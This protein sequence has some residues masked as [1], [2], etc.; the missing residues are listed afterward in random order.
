MTTTFIRIFCI[1]YLLYFQSTTIITAKSQ[2]DVISEFKHALLKN[3][4]ELMQSYVTEGVELP[5]FQKEK[6]IHEIKIVP[7][8]KEDTTILISYFKG[9]NDEFTIGFILEIVTKNNK[10]SL[11]NQIYDG[12]PLMKEATIVK[13]YE[14]KC[15][16]HILTPTKFPFEIHEFQ[17]YI[18]NDYLNL[19]Y[20]N[21]DIN[22]ILKITVSP[23]QN[24]LDFY[25]HRD[26][27]FY[28]LK[29]NIKALYNPHFDSAYELLFQKNG[30]QYTIAIGN[31]RYI[32]G[33]YNIKD[34]IQ[35]AES[36]N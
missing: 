1:F 16:E 20:Y 10:I 12:N 15:K 33:K 24:K 32:Q 8:P 6:P 29:N 13:E 26:A 22:G 18:Y 11:I 17:G 7:S 36:M 25:V 3:D 2:T 19:Q 4:K 23:V 35:I 30:F 31:K 14:M 9:T 27:K 21:E 5:I 28:S 34:L